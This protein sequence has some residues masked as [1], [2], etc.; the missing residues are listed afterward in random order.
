MSKELF[1]LLLCASLASGL[2]A[3]FAL[4]DFG[5]CWPIAAFLAL[6][7][8]LAGYSWR[9]RG[10]MDAS[11][12]LLGLTLALSVSAD[13]NAILDAALECSSGRPCSVD[14][15]VTAPPQTRR[16]ADGVEWVAVPAAVGPVKIRAVFAPRPGEARPRVGERWRFTGWL[17]RETLPN[18]DIR[19]F[20]MKGASSSARRLPDTLAGRFAGAVSRWRGNLSRRVGIG[21]EHDPQAA[22]LN[23]AILLGE[24]AALDA[25]VRDEFASAG[26]IHVFAIS[27]L[28][29]MF[30]AGLLRLALLLI[31]VPLRGAG[32]IAIP[33]IGLYVWLVGCP[34]S[35]IR[36]AL[37][38]ALY[39]SAPIFWRRPNGVVSWSLTFLL[40]HVLSPM[41]LFDVGCRLSFTVML[42]L[43]VWLRWKPDFKIKWCDGFALA[44]VAW[45]AGVPMTARIF[46]RFTLGGLL[47]NPLVI[48]AAGVGVPVG[49]LGCFA[50]FV[51]EELAAHINNF[52]AL[53]TRMMATASSFVANL[54]GASVE[55]VPWSYGMCAAWYV[56]CILSVWL[57]CEYRREVASSGWLTRVPVIC[58]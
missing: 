28:H 39:F 44:I 25:S 36:A 57:V 18:R 7:V 54:P 8:T 24:R 49:V 46:G 30:I 41:C 13:R 20:W 9:V 1:W 15:V 47:A 4:A 45:A 50:S 38:S 29:V 11:I 53:C 21:L 34:P 5:A 42:S 37:M 14:A 32:A 2:A 33:L 10:W 58:G 27:G 22:A 31:G 55:I 12:F 3:G 23:R 26:T 43:V 51:S 17:A 56:A 40:V 16:G 35:A 48:P 19:M 52:A 6:F